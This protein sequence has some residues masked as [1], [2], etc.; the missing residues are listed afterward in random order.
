VDD[1]AELVGD[2]ARFYTSS[3]PPLQQGDI[4][5]APVGRLQVDT[6]ARLRWESLDQVVSEPL[7]IEADLP[8]LFAVAGYGWAIV[9]THDCH[10]D[11]EFNERVRELRRTQR[12][13][14]REAEKLAEEDPEL[15]RFVNVCPLLPTSSFRAE[16]DVL[17]RGDV[18]GAFPIPAVPE[19]GLD[20]LVADL[21]YRATIDRHAILARAGAMSEEARLWLR[22]SLARADAFR[23]PTIG[24]ELEQAVGKRIKAV[25]P[26]SANPL[27]IGLELSDGNTLELINQPA[28][29]QTGGTSRTKAPD[30]A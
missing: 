27:A 19:H 30:K 15:D 21:T 8:E 7:R 4:V 22:F 26:H 6:D 29:V 14:L 20:D 24:F 25:L 13:K 10:L 11:R 2:A 28:E 1:L 12:L 3:D 23:T 16:W 9:A 5:L 17:A 18:I